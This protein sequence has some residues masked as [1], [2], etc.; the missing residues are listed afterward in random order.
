MRTDSV[1]QDNNMTLLWDLSLD[2]P[3]CHDVGSQFSNWTFTIVGREQNMTVVSTDYYAS[4][5]SIG[6]LIP[7]IT[8]DLSVREVN[9]HVI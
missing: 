3:S 8:Y 1:N 7:Y 9:H 4:S 2:S 5:L 6:D